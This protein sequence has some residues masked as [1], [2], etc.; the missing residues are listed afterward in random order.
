M[1]IVTCPV[2]LL[3]IPVYAVT[4]TPASESESSAR[5]VR[6]R[7]MV[8]ETGKVIDSW[9]QGNSK[10]REICSRSR[11]LRTSAFR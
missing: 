6:E 3:P 10:C 11:K 4:T 2:N 8:M 7:G 9:E 1:F 5:P